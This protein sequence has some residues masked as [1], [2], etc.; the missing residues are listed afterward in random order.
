VFQEFRKRISD[1][2]GGKTEVGVGGFPSPPRIQVLA[3]RCATFSG[4]KH[5]FALLSYFF[6]ARKKQDLLPF[7]FIVLPPSVGLVRL[8]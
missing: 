5:F 1:S 8:S 4:L 6:E 2:P 7:E 3:T